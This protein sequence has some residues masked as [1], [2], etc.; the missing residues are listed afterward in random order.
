LAALELVALEL[1]ELEL[2][3]RESVV[4]EYYGMVLQE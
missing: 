2:D 4:L 3:T 1:V